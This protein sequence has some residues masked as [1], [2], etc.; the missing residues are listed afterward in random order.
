MDA[1]HRYTYAL[2]KFPNQNTLNLP[3]QMQQQ[4]FHFQTDSFYLNVEQT[5]I[6]FKFNLYLNLSRCQRKLN[7]YENSIEF[8]NKALSIKS[9]SYEAYYARARAKRD[10]M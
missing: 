1:L 7:N 6:E 4:K 10:N 2:K 5:L 8:C 3:T 9:N